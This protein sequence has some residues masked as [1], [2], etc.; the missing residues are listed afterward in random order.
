MKR[1]LLYKSGD[2]AQ[3]GFV[4]SLKYPILF[5]YVGYK[6]GSLGRWE[7]LSGKSYMHPYHLK[8]TEEPFKCDRS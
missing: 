2:G 7:M 1:C 5:Y 3:K 4:E 8:R 6:H